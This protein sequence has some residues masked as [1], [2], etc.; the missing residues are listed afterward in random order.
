MASRASRIETTKGVLA[1][2]IELATGRM[3]SGQVDD[4][5]SEQRNRAGEIDE[6]PHP[7]HPDVINLHEHDHSYLEHQERKS[8]TKAD[9]TRLSEKHKQQH[10]QRN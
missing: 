4:A 8:Q 5:N 2:G 10:Q 3:I 7:G 9:Q 6:K 1:H